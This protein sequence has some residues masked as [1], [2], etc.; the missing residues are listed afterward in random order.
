M[1]RLTERLSAQAAQRASNSGMYPDGGELYLRV[2]PTGSKHWLLRYRHGGKR[3]DL[4]LGPFR[5]LSLA[6]ARQRARE[7]QRTLRLDGQDPL[8]ERRQRS[9]AE[10]VQSAKAQTLAEV[11]EAGPT[12]G[13]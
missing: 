10:A 12:R 4:G 8:A 3:H 5:L 13:A 11:A 6:E 2:G 9:H 1:A 7:H